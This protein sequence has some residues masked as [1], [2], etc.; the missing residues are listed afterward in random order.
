[1]QPLARADRVRS[2]FVT[3][4]SRSVSL[5]LFAGDD[6]ELS[7]VT[8]MNTPIE[9]IIPRDPQSQPTPMHLQQVTRSNASGLFDL[10]WVNVSAYEYAISIHV[11]MLPVNGS[12]SYLL[13]YKF[14]GTPQVNSSMRDVDGWRLLCAASEFERVC[15]PICAYINV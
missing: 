6:S 3:N 13:I 15:D 11:Q 10:Q 12:R 5:S 2:N 9:L 14:D 8:N 1:M 4:L 7:F